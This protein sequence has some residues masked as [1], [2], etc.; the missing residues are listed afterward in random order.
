[1]ENSGEPLIF[2]NS[3]AF[4]ALVRFIGFA[5][6]AAA[7]LFPF[8]AAW[9]IFHEQESAGQRTKEAVVI[10]GGCVLTA[11]LGLGL[12]S[13]S[14]SMN[15]YEASFEPEGVRFQLGFANKPKVTLIPWSSIVAVNYKMPFNT[16]YASVVTDDGTTLQWSSFEFVRTKKL[17]RAIAARVGQSLQQMP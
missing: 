5:M 8:A 2:R 3:R 15:F 9:K 7:L 14:D 17:A 12:W 16:A 4:T 11:L 6:L 1:M 13:Q 10:L